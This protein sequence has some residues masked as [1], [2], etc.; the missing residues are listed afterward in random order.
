[1]KAAKVPPKCTNGPY[2]PTEAPPPI[3]ISEVNVD[4][5][6]FRTSN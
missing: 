1:M 3:E 2:M 4:R 5:K 6:P